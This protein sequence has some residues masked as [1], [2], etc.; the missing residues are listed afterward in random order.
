VVQTASNAAWGDEAHVRDNRRMYTEKFDK[1]TPLIARHLD[2]RR[3]DA[4]FYLWAKTPIPDTDFARELLRQQN[5]VVLPGSFIAREAGGVN[6]G[7]NFVRIALV[8]PVEQCLDAAH[9]IQNFCH[10]L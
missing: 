1:V 10:S 5:V 7:A 9:R 2:C 3:P 6:P 8:A 4:G